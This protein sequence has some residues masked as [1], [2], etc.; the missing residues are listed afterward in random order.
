MLTW[1][2]RRRRGSTD[3]TNT[4]EQITRDAIQT[5]GE[6][7]VADNSIAQSKIAGK[8]DNQEDKRLDSSVELDCPTGPDTVTKPHVALNAMIVEHRYKK[9]A[10]IIRTQ[11]GGRRLFVKTKT[12]PV[13]VFS[14]RGKQ[15]Y[16]LEGAPLSRYPMLEV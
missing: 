6:A 2:F 9:E 11:A 1:L 15:G 16:Y 7:L 4:D 8:I 12:G 5:H 3:L 10:E 14:K 13:R